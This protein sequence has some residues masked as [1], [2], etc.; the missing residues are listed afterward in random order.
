MFRR[1]AQ[2]VALLA[3]VMLPTTAMAAELPPAPNDPLYAE[4]WSLGPETSF[5]IDL[6]ETWRFGQ[7]DGVVVAVLDSGITDHPEFKG[8]V[9]LATTSLAIRHG[10]V[11]VMA[12]MRTQRTLAIGWAWTML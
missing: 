3:A 4:Q 8:R 9:L 10:R 6:R 12:A 11:M 2:L 5:G 1:T 7:G